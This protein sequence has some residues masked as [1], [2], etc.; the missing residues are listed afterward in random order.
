MNQDKILDALAATGPWTVLTTPT[1][2]DALRD[3]P[4]HRD[5]L[6]IFLNHNPTTVAARHQHHTDRLWINVYNNPHTAIADLANPGDLPA[7]WHLITTDNAAK[8]IACLT[9]HKQPR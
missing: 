7:P 8:T 4:D 5:V 6:L 3:H 9:A 2:I 1:H